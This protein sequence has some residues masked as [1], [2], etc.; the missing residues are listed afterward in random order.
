MPTSS[1]PDERCAVPAVDLRE[2]EEEVPYEDFDEDPEEDPE[3]FPVDLTV[4]PVRDDPE[5]ER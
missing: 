1:A 4:R 5:V 2:R 3:D